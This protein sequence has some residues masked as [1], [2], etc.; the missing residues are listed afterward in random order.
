MGCDMRTVGIKV[1]MTDMVG[2]GAY[3]KVGDYAP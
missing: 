3:A 2:E 1:L